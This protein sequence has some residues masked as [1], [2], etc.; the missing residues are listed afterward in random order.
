MIAREELLT[1]MKEGA[2]KPLG[3]E[4]LIRELKVPEEELEEFRKLLEDML[5]RGELVLTK[6]MRVALP[7]HMG[8]IPG[9]IQGNP[10]G[11]GFM[12]PDENRDDGDFFIAPRDLNGAM[13]GDRVLVRENPGSV[14]GR[15]DATVEKILQRKHE[16]IMGTFEKSKKFGFVI[17]DNTRIGQDIYITKKKH[18][19]AN[20]GDKVL[21]KITKW[22]SDRRSAEGKIVEVLGKMGD[23]GIDIL[24]I[25]RS[26][27]LREE[28]P[29]DVAEQARKV[30]RNVD[31]QEAASKDRKDLRDLPMV[32]IDGADAKDLDDAVSIRREGD[33]YHLG[34]HI[35]DVSH[36][37][38]PGTVLDEEALNRATSVYF[39]DRVL[40]MLP[41]E[42]SNGICS[43]NAGTDRL[44]MSCLMKIDGQGNVVSYEVGPSVIHVD[45]RMT[46]DDV[47]ALLEEDDKNLKKR[48]ERFAGDF[49]LLKQLM[50]ILKDKRIRRGAIDF[51]FPEV[52]II[53]NDDGSVRELK[54]RTRNVAESII[55][56]CMLVANETVAEHLYNLEVPAV[57][58]VH[59]PPSTKKLDIL[60]SFLEHYDMK[61]QPDG[62][63]ASPRD[64]QEILEKIQ[65][66]PHEYPTSLMM[67]RSMMHARYAV[68]AL[69]HF[70]LAAKFYCHFTSPIRRYPDLFVHRSIRATM[71]GKVSEKKWSR[72]QEQAVEAATI[73]S[74]KEIQ[75]E[76]AEREAVKLKVVQYMA[77]HVGSTFT[78]QI[79][80]VIASGFFVMLDNLAEGLVKAS[81]LLDQFYHYDEK[82]MR[83]VGERD[84]RAFGIGEK[85]EVRLVKADT[86]R[87]TLDFELEEFING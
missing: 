52:K 60:N 67:L 83:L 32:T 75:A 12:I 57:Y 45:E 38:Q 51:E 70:G 61:I 37:V 58:R 10:K 25:V 53:L 6:K 86:V 78:A 55:E 62:D 35:A 73:S 23:P 50:R 72:L 3:E 71:G 5:S 44:A 43:L 40:P 76:E 47:N 54:K 1:F 7:W 84:G 82:K 48:Y 80:G 2:Y 56:E 68:D 29:P 17:P 15:R 8:L 26:H 31:A 87:Q 59:E 20:T 63:H 74:E 66:E 14:A 69:G 9:R 30:P 21:V 85:V 36:Y 22:P 81:T 46:Y 79:S 16:T 19:D 27:D 41:V 65:K 28:F 13:D 39:P 49:D 4:D 33:H 11:F 77:E 64:Y 24:A 18:M 42:L 34:V